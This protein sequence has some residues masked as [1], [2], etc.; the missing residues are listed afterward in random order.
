V[1]ELESDIRAFVDAANA[2]PKPFRW[3]K[4][5]DDVLAGVRRFR[6]RTIGAAS[7]EEA[8]AR[9]SESGH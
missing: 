2:A 1:A 8:M 7:A 3:V 6:L 9:T 4:S 5:A